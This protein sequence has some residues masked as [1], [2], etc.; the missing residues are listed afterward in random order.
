MGIEHPE[1]EISQPVAN[2]QIPNLLNTLSPD[3]SVHLLC[4]RHRGGCWR[5]CIDQM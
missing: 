5:Y 2:F 4:A 1:Q 3:V